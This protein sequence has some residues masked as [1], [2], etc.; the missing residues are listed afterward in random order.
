MK[1]I[2]QKTSQNR[3]LAREIGVKLWN[4]VNGEKT[5]NVY[6]QVVKVWHDT[7]W[8]EEAY[9]NDTMNN[10]F[11]MIGGDEMLCMSFANIK[12][13]KGTEWTD[14][15]SDIRVFTRHK[16]YQDSYKVQRLVFLCDHFGNSCVNPEQ[17]QQQQSNDHNMLRDIFVHLPSTRINS[18]AQANKVN[19]GY[20]VGNCNWML[21]RPAFSR[22]IKFILFVS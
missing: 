11:W 3:L 7:T 22:K 1:S 9:R 6:E 2:S 14:L 18:I 4:S 12:P 8:F 16:I 13:T 17:Q 19:D 10:I 20:L 5:K 21:G 15:T